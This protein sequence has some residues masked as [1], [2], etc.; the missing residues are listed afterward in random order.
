MTIQ[1]ECECKE[2]PEFDYE[3]LLCRVIEASLDEEGC[4]YE[5][6]V[7]VVLTDNEEIH[8]V[9]K[10]FRNI[11]QP[12]DVLSFPMLEYEV[13]G[14]FDFLEERD[15]CFHPESGELLLGDIM[16]SVER[17]LEQAVEYGHSLEREMA[18]LTVH[19]VLHLCGYDHMEEEERL[20]MEEKQ[21][22]IL[23]K[24]RITRD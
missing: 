8:R 23:D 6:E 20:I 9:N 16:I 7:N 5:A 11:D 2:T 3:E 21:R 18:F 15:D 22:L 14:N 4:P 17:A 10:E 19:S 24:L 13:P 1:I 12:T